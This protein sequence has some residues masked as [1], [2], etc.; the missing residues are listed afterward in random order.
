[1]LCVM[2]NKVNLVWSMETHE[3]DLLLIIIS[4][5]LAD[6]TPVVPVLALGVTAAS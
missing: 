2:Y 3:S 1:M 4:G 5:L 6:T